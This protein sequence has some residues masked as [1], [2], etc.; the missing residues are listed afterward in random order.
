MNLWPFNFIGA[1][2]NLWS[3]DSGEDNVL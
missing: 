2:L 1:V 3:S